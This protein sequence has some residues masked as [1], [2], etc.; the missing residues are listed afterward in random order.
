[1]LGAMVLIAQPQVVGDRLFVDSS[2]RFDLNF[3]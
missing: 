3:I 2:Q 1:M